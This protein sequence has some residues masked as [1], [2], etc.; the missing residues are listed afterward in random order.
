MFRNAR[1]Q[2]F[3]DHGIEELDPENFYSG[4]NSGIFPTIFTTVFRGQPFP[5]PRGSNARNKFP[6]RLSFFVTCYPQPRFMSLFKPTRNT[7]IASIQ[8][9]NKISCHPRNC[10]EKAGLHPSKVFLR[11]CVCVCVDNF[12]HTR[13]R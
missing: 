8:P 10:R 6:H 12:L 9:A 13:S 1:V 3:L 4:I 7:V 11:G 5:S 2:S